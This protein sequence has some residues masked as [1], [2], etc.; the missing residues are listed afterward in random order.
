[1]LNAVTTGR[2]EGAVVKAGRIKL[3]AWWLAWG[4][5]GGIAGGMAGAASSQTTRPGELTPTITLNLDNAT[6]Q[7][8]F[9]ELGRQGGVKFITAPS[10]LLNNARF[11]KP[12][13]LHLEQ[14]Y[15]WPAMLQAC[16]ATGLYPE[17]YSATALRLTLR[18]GGTP[19]GKRPI[20]F[21][22]SFLI[23]A[24]RISRSRSVEFSDPESSNH[25]E[26]TYLQLTVFADP[27]VRIGQFS[28]QMALEEVKDENGVSLI[29]DVSRQYTG[30]ETPRGLCW[31]LNVNLVKPENAGMRIATFKGA[32]NAT[33]FAR[34]DKWEIN[35]VLKAQ[36]VNKTVGGVVYTLKKVTAQNATTYTVELAARTTNS[37]TSLP[38]VSALTTAQLLDATGTP[39]VVNGWGGPNSA[40]QLYFTAGR[41]ESGQLAGAPVK[42]VLDLP[43]GTRP[44]TIPVNFTDLPL[45]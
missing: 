4:I 16:D 22:D 19:W 42:F 39:Y 2:V 23:V 36:N 5:A 33:V 34:V 17:T 38:G 30:T 40:P 37:R 35:D 21:S 43:V 32:I 8:I 1:M 29:P 44:I 6:P 20:C 25:E 9:T 24:E 7:D 45:P 14:Q 18:E 26:Q 41:N 13:S 15:F 28:A 3:W 10:N 27:K 31:N 11:K 12:L